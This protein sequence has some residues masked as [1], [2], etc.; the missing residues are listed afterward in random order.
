M[1]RLVIAMVVCCLGLGGMAW[2]QE[3]QPEQKAPEQA[4]KAV[5][6]DA[7]KM[8]EVVVTATKT[9]EERRK[10]P[11]KVEVVKGEQLQK[12]N[13][14]SIDESVRHL[15]GMAD[16]RRSGVLGATDSKVAVNMRGFSQA[17]QNLVMV[18]G[19]PV[20]NY[21]GYAQWWN[22][23]I[24]SVDHIEVVKGPMSSLYG[25]G[26][27][28]GVINIITKTDYS[29]LS[30]SLGYGSYDTDEMSISSG[31][32][33]KDVGY[34]IAYR[35]LT[36]DG[37]EQVH[38]SRTVGEVV[39]TAQPGVTRRID[40]YQTWQTTTEALDMGLTWDITTDSSLGV[41]CL[42]STF[43]MDPDRRKNNYDGADI[44]G[45]YRA[46]DSV[47]YGLNYYNTML[48]NVEVIVNAGLINNYNDLFI[49]R[50]GAGDSRCPNSRYNLGAQSNITLPYNNI[51]TIGLDSSL[52]RLTSEDETNPASP[53]STKGKMQTAGLFLQDQW[54][55]TDFLILYA[56]V[57]YDYW[58]SY[59]GDTNNP[60]ALDISSHTE[61]YVSPKLS[62]VLLPDDKTTIRASAGESFRGPTIWEVFRYRRFPGKDS[63][64]LPNPD[65]K[66][67][68]ARSYEAGIERIF[69]DRL[70]LG[71][72]YFWNHLDDMIYQ[73]TLTE[74]RSSTQVD[75]DAQNQNVAKAYSKGYELSASCKAMEGVLLYANYTRTDTRI[76][77]ASGSSQAAIIEG[78]QFKNIPKRMYNVGLT[79][80]KYGLFTDVVMHHMG[81]RYYNDDNSDTIDRRYG[82]LD[83]FTVYDVTL[84][85]KFKHF[86]VSGTVCNATDKEFWESFDLNPGRTYMIK[87]SAW[88]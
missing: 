31:F 3:G 5:S 81:D 29:P 35:K 7:S 73:V 46:Q 59:G 75:D 87:A 70:T 44:T 56:G 78:K 62:V 72:T 17:A 80:E 76:T 43:E 12:T 65:L 21:E 30:F 53:Q 15:P 45:N 32:R 82:G 63:V 24:A 42:Y 26:A 6:K 88:F 37:N 9:K 85:Y 33:I 58:K 23:P 74:K 67:E 77:D 34:H 2:A 39:E 38:T 13:A 18:D 8:P 16:S 61:S 51:L 79:I 71:G 20:N 55:A 10:T 49:M 83:P 22:F 28:G 84:G 68:T 48:E 47:I 86:S 52:A 66:P 64:V 41:K 50:P 14:A 25:S 4:A 11:S 1:K 54:K 19:Q 69:F 57:R 40:G 36:T 27:M 60:T